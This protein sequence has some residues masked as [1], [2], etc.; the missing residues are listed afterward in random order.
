M[1]NGHVLLIHALLNQALYT[2]VT[3]WKHVRIH[4]ARII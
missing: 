2:S 3:L 1:V 4:F